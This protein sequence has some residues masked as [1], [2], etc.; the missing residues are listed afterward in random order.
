MRNSLRLLV[1]PF[2]AAACN[3]TTTGD[4]G[5]VDFTPEDCGEGICT[6]DSEL[7]SS[8]SMVVA[9]DA[10]YEAGPVTVITDD[11]RVAIVFPL[12]H[13]R[14]EVRG[15][16][17]GFTR[18]VVLTRYEELDSTPLRVAQTYRYGLETATPNAFQS[19]PEHA[20]EEI[21][22]LRADVATTFTVR[23][24]DR[25]G[26]ELM[27]VPNLTTEIDAELFDAVSPSSNLP[28]G[29]L[30]LNA[31]LPGDYFM[32]VSADGVYLDV[33]FEAR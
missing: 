18:L 6:L 1:I 24:Y 17:P 10:P 21:W 13:D 26:F 28:A 25:H 12:T 31:M 7:A 27:G 29:E 32:T 15:I 20:G 23:P 14:W 22:Q 9:V 16:N 8:T 4:R 19:A 30:L 11:A 2:L 33:V 5:V 3:V